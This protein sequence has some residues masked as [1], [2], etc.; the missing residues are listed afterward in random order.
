MGVLW[1]VIRGWGIA[2]IPA[3][4]GIALYGIVN[5]LSRLFLPL[6]ALIIL[7]ATGALAGV[8]N[9]DTAWS[10]RDHQRRSPSW[11]LRRSSS[12]SC[13]PNGLQTGSGGRGNGS[14]PG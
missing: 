1:V 5:E 2:N 13:G 8:Q 10:D 14:S 4:S 6:F 3:T 7:W 9:A 11:S 12:P